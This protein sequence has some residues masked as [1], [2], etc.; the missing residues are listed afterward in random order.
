MRFVSYVGM[1]HGTVQVT[2]PRD[3]SKRPVSP[4]HVTLTES[5]TSE[6]LPAESMSRWMT[7]RLAPH[8][9]L[10]RYTWKLKPDNVAICSRG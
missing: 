10:Q 6:S 8:V 9:Y 5:V 7:F 4:L 3:G 2:S 1:G